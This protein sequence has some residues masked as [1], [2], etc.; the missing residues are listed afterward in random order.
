M[1][2]IGL[3]QKPFPEDFAAA[4]A[5]IMPPGAEPLSLFTSIAQSPRA[6]DRFFGG[7]MASRG[8][9]DFRTREIIIDRTAAKTGCEYEWGTHVKLFATKAG[10]TDAQVRSTYDGHADDGNW[11][12]TE[13][14]LIATVDALLA[15]RKLSDAEFARIAAQFD[16][17]QILEIIQ[18]V[19]FYHGVALITGAIDLQCEPGML[20]FPQD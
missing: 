6:L 8:P 10:L 9:L 3:L 11:N 14:A 20:R 4:M 5:R 19:N 7:S 2:R 17:A 18:L 12:A 13:A 15:N 1:S 16:T